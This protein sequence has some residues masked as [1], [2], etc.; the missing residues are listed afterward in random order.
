MARGGARGGWPVAFN[1][2]KIVSFLKTKMHWHQARQQVLAQN[3]AHADTPNYRPHELAP[4][5]FED[6]MA[7]RTTAPVVAMRTHVSHIPGQPAQAGRFATQ[8]GN[9]W[10]VRPAGNSVVLEEQMMNVAANQFD[11]QLASTL[12]SRSLGLIRSALGRQS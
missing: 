5:R 8:E 10:E 2:L 6:A 11:Y 4:L 1:D 7:A 3:V 9:G 12:Y